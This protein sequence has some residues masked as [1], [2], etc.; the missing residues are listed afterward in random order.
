MLA[1]DDGPDGDDDLGAPYDGEIPASVRMAVKHV[2]EATG[3]RSRRRMARALLISGAPP[4]AV[5]A[6]REPPC[7]VCHEKRAPKTRRVSS[8]PAP[9]AVGE[10]MHLDL[11]MVDDALGKIPRGGARFGCHQQ[12]PV[13]SLHPQQ[14]FEGGLPVPEP[15]VVPPAWTTAGHGE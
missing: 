15:D 8:L 4:A 10:Q 12:I 14:I 11:L 7:E 13:G 2:R 5:Q 6:A 3:H 9:R 1:Q